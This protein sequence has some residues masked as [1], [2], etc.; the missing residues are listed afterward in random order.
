[1][2]AMFFFHNYK[3]SL[4]EEKRGTGVANVDR[5][6]RDQSITH[7]VDPVLRANGKCPFLLRSD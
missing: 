5:T 7:V 4:L 3:L 6:V 1:M 2:Y